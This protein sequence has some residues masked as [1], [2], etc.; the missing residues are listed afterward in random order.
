LM[1]EQTVRT[2]DANA[3]LKLVHAS[4]GKILRA[5]PISALF[6]QRRAHLAGSFPELEDQMATY[7]AGTPGS[8]DRLDGMTWAMTELMLTS[9]ADGLGFFEYMRRQYEAMIAEKAA[10]A[11]RAN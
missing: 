8:P 11:A 10:P 1:V 6:E 2:V 7:A 5:E 3:S 9:P 4:R